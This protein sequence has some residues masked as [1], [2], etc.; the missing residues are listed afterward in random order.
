MHG[1]NWSA[2]PINYEA[3]LEV[4]AEAER[5]QAFHEFW[6][7]MKSGF[8]DAQMH[9]VD[10]AAVR[11]RYEP[12]LAGIET[13]E[14]FAFFLL[15]PMAGELNASHAEVSPRAGGDE[16]AT[17]ST[18]LWFDETYAG[19]G[20]R[21]VGY[22][23]GG[24]N[25]DGSP[26]IRPGE[27]IL[28][29]NGEE[30]VWGERL[31]KVLS[32]RA[33]KETEVVVNGKPDQEGAR[34]VKLRPTTE[35]R[36]RELIYEE[37]VQRARETV[38]EWGEG[39]IAYIRVNAMDPPSLRRF[40]REIW[41]EAQK[42]EALILDVRDNGGGSTH[43]QILGQLARTLYGYTK[44]RDG[45]FSTQPF[46]LWSKPVVLVINENSASD[47]ELFALGFRTLGLG[48]I[49]GTRTPGYVIGTYSATLPDGTSYRIPMWGWY[50]RELRNLENA[51]VAPD[52]EAAG[53]A[54][55]LGGKDD[56]QLRKAVEVLIK[57]LAKP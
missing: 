12:L 2:T 49:V 45:D 46:R 11:D 5:R 25:D 52:I 35:A 3:E 37:D 43:D 48:P 31:W 6:R 26:V 8:Y 54:Q 38:S 15:A 56:E 16:P 19:P 17:A 7:S 21:V 22:V 32:G 47:A 51:G 34:T 40:E 53:P 27:Y 18:G 9:G 13:P 39:R 1:S 14:E 44:P 28:K 41:G 57:R 36:V 29:V 50:T 42:A 23:K 55:R 30:V 24:P 4:D 10:W 20:V 33:D